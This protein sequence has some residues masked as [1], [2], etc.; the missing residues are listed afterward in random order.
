MTQ[1]PLAS[2]TQ[3][4]KSFLDKE[5]SEKLYQYLIQNHDLSNQKANTIDGVSHALE[6]GKIMFMDINL[7]KHNKLPKSL[8]GQT[9]VWPKE[10]IAVKKKVEKHTG[11]KF[12]VCVLI[13]YQ[14][15]N[16]GVG[17][18]SDFVA[19]GDTSLIPSL[20]LGEERVFYLRDKQNHTEYSIKLENGSLLIMGENCQE[21]FEHS[22]PIDPKY[23]NPRIN[24]T[25]RTYGFN[26][27]S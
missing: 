4:I 22:L 9:A 20:S 21:L 25:F 19:F 2:N 13:Y 11:T 6:H 26:D 8:W 27:P 23:K 24:L 14:D 15:G 10:L 1:L 18:H 16:V 7:Y 3:Y 5:E 17:Y 12:Q